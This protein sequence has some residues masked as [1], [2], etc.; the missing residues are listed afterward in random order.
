M[1]ELPIKDIIEWDVLNWSEIIKE[2]TPIVEA[3]PRGSK[4]LAVGERDGGL[5]LWL[6]L[7][8]FNVTCTDRI[9]PTEA[10]GKQ[11]QKYGVADKISYGELDIV[12]CDWEGEQYDLI[13]IKS[14]IGGVMAVYGDQNT[15]NFD[16]QKRAVD[17]MHHLLK[18]GGVLLSVENM[19]GN[20]LMHLMRKVKGKHVGWHHFTWEEI[21]LLYS[22]FGDVTT[23][24][25]GVLPTLF[26]SS[27]INNIAYFFNK[28]LLQFLPA[29]TKYIAITT[30][31][32]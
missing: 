21:G 29:K 9:G 31:R 25:F 7:L 20:I 23:K 10:A 32:K 2:W 22:S 14:V 27:L 12:N 3:L 4:V 11:H 1:K 30:A 26:P 13:V 18:K 24:A 5:S 19:K 6:A 16:V 8:G 15:R 28:Y 17:N